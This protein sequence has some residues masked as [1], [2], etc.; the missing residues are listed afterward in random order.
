[1]GPVQRLFQ[2]DT[3]T[4]QYTRSKPLS[5]L[6]CDK[7]IDIDTSSQP[8]TGTNIQNSTVLKVTR[9]ARV[10]VVACALS[11]LVTRSRSV[12]VVPKC[13][14]F[15][16]PTTR[17]PIKPRTAVSSTWYQVRVFRSYSVLNVQQYIAGREMLHDNR[18]SDTYTIATAY[19]ATI[20]LSNLTL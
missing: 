4:C 20:K 5:N 19:A 15:C 16:T 6:V 13:T 1:M 3:G 7:K 18:C 8:G 14:M 17:L 10:R 11:R 12:L 9:Q 2:E